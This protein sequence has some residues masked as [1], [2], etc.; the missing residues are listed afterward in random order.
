MSEQIGKR[1]P[2]IDMDEFERRLRKPLARNDRDDD[3]LAELARFVG[4]QEDPYKS[5]FESPAHHP[6]GAF[7]GQDRDDNN[8]HW[9]QEPLIRGDFAAIEAGLLG[10]ARNN[11]AAAHP[12]EAELAIAEDLAE[13]SEH[14]RYE[15]VPEQSE[16]PD[17]PFEEIRSRRPLYLMAAVIVA[18]I[19]GIGASFALKGSVSSQREIATI[20]APEG[21]A[22]V[23]TETVA[24][25]EAPGQDA[26][27]LGG[28]PQQMPVAA[29][30]RAEQPSDLSAAAKV[31]EEQVAAP[32]VAGG[33]AHGAA[34][35]PVPPPPAAQAQPQQQAEP[36]SI[37][38]L[39]EPKKVRTVSV[40]PDG[41]LLPNDTPPQAGSQ[42]PSLPAA[43]RAP[44]QPAAKAATPKSPGHVATTPKPASAQPQHT[45]VA[46]K[47]KPVQIAD[48]GAQVPA[49]AAPAGTFAVQFAAPASEQEA[50]EAQ[51]KLMKK[52]GAE[53]AGFHP[54]IRKAEVGGKPVYRVRVGGLTS[55]DEAT[56]LCQKVQSGGGSCFVAKN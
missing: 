38:A 19:A 54:S 47:A 27:I 43:A 30:D 28:A 8:G 45:S 17:S 14:W 35:V 20:K 22:K 9:P 36:L 46:A 55:R 18:G 51:V 50:R 15:E 39:I 49:G 4:G 56:A 37:A 16:N 53:L 11:S 24:S 7:S 21:P 34:S 3:P 5:V 1:R 48:A 23:A 2:M 32:A 10:V 26:S 33:A 52:F 40:L 13:Q 29:I 6:A 31:A 42:A 44:A 12:D 41:T 25:A